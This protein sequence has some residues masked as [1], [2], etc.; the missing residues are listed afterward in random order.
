MPRRVL[1]LC[2]AL[3]ALCV[4]APA[5]TADV[6]T[7]GDGVSGGLEAAST[8]ATVV[9]DCAI[10]APTSGTAIVLATS[11]LRFVDFNYEARLALSLD[12]P[13]V[14]HNTN[15]T[16][17]FVNIYSDARNKSA[18]TQ[19]A[20]A[21]APGRHTFRLILEHSGAG[22]AGLLDPSL[23]VIF[24]PSGEPGIQVCSDNPGTTYSNDTTT[25]S[26]I[27][28]CSITA[29]TAGSLVGIG[30]GSVGFSG[31]PF[32][33][34][35]RL[36][37]DNPSG[38]ASTERFLNIYADGFDGTDE[39]LSTHSVTPVAAGAHTLS[40]IG[41]RF[42]TNSGEGT[43]RVLDAGLVGLFIADGASTK[44]CGASGTDAWTN[45]TSTDT[46]VRSCSLTVTKKSHVL[47][48]AGGSAAM[49]APAGAAAE[50]EGSFGL[51]VGGTRV[52]RLVNVYYDGDPRDGTDR[53]VSA[54]MFAR[55][56]PAGPLEVRFLGRRAVGTGVAKL[57][58]P[59]LAA[60]AIPA[61]DPPPVVPPP[62]LPTFG[63]KTLVT[64]KLASKKIAKS[65]PMPVRVVNRNTF[66]VTGSLAGRTSRKVTASSSKKKRQAKPKIV[67]LK[68]K[69]FTV[70]ANGRTTV[71][72][73]L[74]RSLRKLLVRKK[75]LSLRVTAT[76]KDPAGRVRTAK[77]TVKPKLRAKKKQKKN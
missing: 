64:L 33:A 3:A 55:D 54:S 37:V 42:G 50:W 34:T 45:S 23:Q 25:A 9:A 18:A 43:V 58:A 12:S 19:M 7:C 40:L 22:T 21:V 77:A 8:S 76:V 30:S 14:D 61:V 53:A 32:E 35:F 63:T 73:S 11:G 46:T 49:Q 52:N 36:G 62:A 1:A 47:A 27:R 15:P 57:I 68:A 69:A 65:G 5:A 44:V 26:T 75:K 67:K 28:S 17:R 29:P 51:A 74:P 13:T 66:A 38:D 24:V 2:F 48:L 16:S 72:L 31:V 59:G 70:K 71:K 6:L 10:S 41:N 39:S 60:L 20:Y 4:C 56:V